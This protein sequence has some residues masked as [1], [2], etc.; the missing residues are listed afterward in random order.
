MHKLSVPMQMQF[1][2]SLIQ[3]LSHLQMV[4]LTVIHSGTTNHVQISLELKILTLINFYNNFYS[5][6]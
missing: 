3:K 6:I 4:I 2:F 1:A 5:I